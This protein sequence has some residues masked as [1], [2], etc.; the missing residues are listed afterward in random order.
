MHIY[1][2]IYI[3]IYIVY[4]YIHIY[5][6]DLKVMESRDGAQ[7]HEREDE[8]LHLARGGLRLNTTGEGEKAWLQGYLAHKKTPN[9]LGPSHHP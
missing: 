5:R 4:V 3:H 6:R 7:R 1:I 2:Y 8:T 9:P